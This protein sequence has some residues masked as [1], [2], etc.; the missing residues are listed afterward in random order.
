GNTLLMSISQCGSSRIGMN[1]PEMKQ[2]GRTSARTTGWAASVLLISEAAAKPRQQN[3]IVPKARLT[4]ST[5]TVRAVICAAIAAQPTAN[6]TATIRTT[7][8]TATSTRPA[9]M[10]LGDIGVAR[11]RL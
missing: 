3:T 10:V 2:I 5:G 11:R 9:M 7:D 6:R 8:K 1:T 4:T